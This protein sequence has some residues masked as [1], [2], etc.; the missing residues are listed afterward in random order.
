MQKVFNPQ[1]LSME[2]DKVNEALNNL[3][4]GATH[5]RRGILVKHVS[6][7][8]HA[9]RCYGR[10]AEQTVHQAL[11]IPGGMQKCARQAL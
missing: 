5:A 1:I 10:E 3:S 8:N 4:R 6:V 9:E 11:A 2:V 7:C